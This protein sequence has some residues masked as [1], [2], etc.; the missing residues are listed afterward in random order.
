MTDTTF[1]T[2]TV[3]GPTGIAAQAEAHIP[4][5]GTEPGAFLATAN[6]DQE[7]TQ[8]LLP[9]GDRV[10]FL[11][12]RI[13]I[14]GKTLD[15]R[16]LLEDIEVQQRTEGFAA[17]TFAVAIERP[18]D[19]GKGERWPLGSPWALRA[20]PPGLV[21]ITIQGFYGTTSGLKIYPLVTNG[22]ANEA[23]LD[24]LDGVDV[25]L[26]R[27][28]GPGARHQRRLVS[29]QLPADHRTPRGTVARRLAQ[30]A[31]VSNISIPAGQAMKKELTLDRAP[32]LDTARQLLELEGRHLTWSEDGT[33]TTVPRLPPLSGGHQGVLTARDILR[34]GFRI[35]WQSDVPTRIRLTSEEEVLDT[36][37]GCGS[38][39]R[40]TTTEVFEDGLPNRAR[41]RINAGLGGGGP[42]TLDAVNPPPGE[43]P[44]LHLVQ[45]VVT[46]T[47]EQCG[48]VVS[49]TVR[50]Y[51]PKNP[52]V[53]RY[54]RGTAGEIIF[55][56]RGA[57]LYEESPD[58]SAE[59]SEATF[60]W[61]VPR[62]VLVSEE[63][64][65]REFEDNLL[66]REVISTKGWYLQRWALKQKPSGG[67]FVSWEEEP[68]IIP[69]FTLGNGE[70]V[71]PAALGERYSPGNVGSAVE[72]SSIGFGQYIERSTL[73]YEIEGLYVVAETTTTEAPHV[74][75][76][77]SHLYQ[78]DEAGGSAFQEFGPVERV[79]ITYSALGEASSLQ[80]TTTVDL[81]ANG[82]GRVSSRESEEFGSYLPEAERLVD[83]TDPNFPRLGEARPLEASC[84]ADLLEAT[85]PRF[86]VDG[87]SD[88]AETVAELESLCL[89]RLRE[90]ALIE[91][92]LVLPACFGIRKGAVLH[93]V[94]PRIDLQHN[95]LVREV[96]TRG[97]SD[98]ITT[99]LKGVIRAL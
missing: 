77:T 54:R 44:A 14:D 31:G 33:L 22:L 72:Q 9:R 98:G 2:A 84:K 32:W 4:G 95:M 62:F 88:W 64:T 51:E 94:L 20:P 49:I 16:W 56:N 7:L 35:R 63:F 29:L 24:T 78:G 12:L 52:E 66:R 27:G 81:L 79:T 48:T 50:T 18:G 70:S 1:F 97:G 8:A 80:T 17:F 61:V 53:W 91:A 13:L 67:G 71:G 82:T 93:G 11:G 90:G 19:D 36:E 37:D 42:W 38:L 46:T 6:I 92:E 26:I 59:G 65:I 3:V 74:P 25:L 86:E 15:P 21:S 41:W 39:T 43:V 85:H 96:I 34:P 99:A 83:G 76:G 5:D 69:A 28:L 10:Q 73:E 30:L 89:Q 40:I 23:E 57:Y 45:R 55:Q 75:P 68:F 87:R 47:E 58:L 60:Q